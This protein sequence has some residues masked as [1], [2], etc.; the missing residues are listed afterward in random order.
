GSSLGLVRSAPD[1]GQ[2]RLHDGPDEVPAVR[3]LEDVRR[4]L[5]GPDLFFFPV[6][7]VHCRRHRGHSVFRANV[8]RTIFT[9][10]LRAPGTG[11]HREIVLFSRPPLATTTCLVVAWR[12]PRRPDERVPGYTR[13]GN[14]DGPIEPG[15]RWNMEAR[16]A[17]A[18]AERVP[19]ATA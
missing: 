2:V 18:R 15:A 4:E 7:D 1:P 8:D 3:V 14:A 10:E 12:P 6:P 17:R 11:P 16:G 5:D 19:R 13:E 9:Y